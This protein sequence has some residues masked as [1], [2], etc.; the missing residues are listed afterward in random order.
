MLL[1]QPKFFFLFLSVLYCCGIVVYSFIIILIHTW[2]LLIKNEISKLSQYR[3]IFTI[4]NEILLC[5]TI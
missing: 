4:L 3:K 1:E 5:G 2:F